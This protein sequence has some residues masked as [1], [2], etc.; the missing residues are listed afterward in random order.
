MIPRHFG[1]FDGPGQEPARKPDPAAPCPL[2][3][4]PLGPRGRLNEA[5]RS[6]LVTTS[7]MTP[8]SSRSYFYGLH[9]ACRD[10]ATADQITDI[11]SVVVDG[12]H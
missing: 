11:E 12:V 1:Y 3:G 8:G 5:G 4:K 10:T 7:L 2:C 9:R 6:V